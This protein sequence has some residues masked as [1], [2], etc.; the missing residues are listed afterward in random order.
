MKAP[1]PVF[2]LTGL[3]TALGLVYILDC[4]VSGTKF[5]GGCYMQGVSLFTGAGGFALGYVTPN[6]AIDARRR[7][8]IL[9]DVY[10]MPPAGSPPPDPGDVL[11]LTP[12]GGVPGNLWP[13]RADQRL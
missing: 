4:R 1:A 11:P 3:L 2:T 8:E 7:K 6:P 9:E 12:P 10:R 13:A 5:D